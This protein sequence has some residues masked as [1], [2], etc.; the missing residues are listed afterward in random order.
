MSEFDKKLTQLKADLN[1][2][3]AR[4]SDQLLQSVESSFDG[5]AEAAKKVI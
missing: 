1:T 4:V 3:G 2:Q 5:N